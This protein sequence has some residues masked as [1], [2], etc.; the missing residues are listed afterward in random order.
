MFA[1]PH[2][3][4]RICLRSQR[5]KMI[6][7]AR[8]C[9]LKERLGWQQLIFWAAGSHIQL[10]NGQLYHFTQKPE[11]LTVESSMWRVFLFSKALILLLA[12]L[13]CPVHMVVGVWGG[14][15]E[16]QFNPSYPWWEE[17]NFLFHPSLSFCESPMNILAAGDS[18]PSPPRR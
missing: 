6:S 14:E 12:V 8:S 3:V 16:N 4:E 18:Q 15:E 13:Q 1:L 5:Q 2:R 11:E 10:P 7:S 9:S 17:H